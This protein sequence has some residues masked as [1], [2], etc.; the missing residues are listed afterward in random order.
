MIYEF[1]DASQ[2]IRQG[3]IFFGIPRIEISLSE[4]PL[5]EDD[6]SVDTT[7]DDVVESGQPLVTALVGVRPVKAIVITQDCDAIRASQITLCEIRPFTDVERASAKTSSPK[8][9]V[10]IITQQARKNLKWFYLPIDARLGFT[11]KMGVDFQVTL[12]VLREDL[13]SLRS[14]RRGRL[15]REA[16]EHFRERLSEYFRRYPYDEWYALDAAE[17]ASYKAIYSDVAP[18]P[19]QEDATHRGDSTLV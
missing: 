13:E 4:L 15:N 12:S 5:V 9:W 2:P 11:E 1:P 17:L 18:K 10:S 14:R 6:T 3:D 7:W 19:W 16:D 8:S